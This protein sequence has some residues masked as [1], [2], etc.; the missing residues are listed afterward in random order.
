MDGRVNHGKEWIDGVFV[1]CGWETKQKTR[2]ETPPS[3]T[4][5]TNNKEKKKNKGLCTR[6][7]LQPGTTFVHSFN[8]N[9]NDKREEG[10]QHI[11]E[12]GEATPFSLSRLT[13]HHSI[14]Q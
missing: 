11:K 13:P 7:F 14:P 2:T 1:L 3:T 10:H 12:E 6:L 8:I 5:A 4:T 9:N